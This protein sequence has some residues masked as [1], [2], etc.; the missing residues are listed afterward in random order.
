MY[1][2]GKYHFKILNNKLHI[3]CCIVPIYVSLLLFI[4]YNI[5]YLTVIYLFCYIIDTQ[6]VFEFVN[7][8]SSSIINYHT[9]DTYNDRFISFK[10]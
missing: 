1:N 5:M 4:L 3:L 2:F 9:T 10:F 8:A 7:M 6:L